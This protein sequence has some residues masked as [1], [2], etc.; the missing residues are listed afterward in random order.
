MAK[1]TD[2]CWDGYT[3]VGMKMKNGKK[4]PNCVPAKGVPKSKPKKKAGKKQCV[5]NVGAD[6]PKVS[7]Q[8]DA[9]AIVL[10]ASQPERRNNVQVFNSKTEEDCWGGKASR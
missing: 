7:Q 9:S 3:Q 5:L 8:R 10:L 2:P 6:A 1:K 4:V